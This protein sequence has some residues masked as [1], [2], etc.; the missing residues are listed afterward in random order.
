[1]K[2]YYT[3]GA[4]SL[5]AHIILNETGLPHEVEQVDLKAKKTAS[6]GDYL[7]INPRGAVPALEI[8]PG[9]VL[10]Q[11]VAVLTYIGAQSDIPA[12]H[13][14][15]G[16]LEQYRLLEAIGFCEDV[17]SAFGPMFAPDLPD[18]VRDRQLA[19]IK[20][21]M[22]Q[23][24]AMLSASGD[25]HMLPV[26]FT[27]ADALLAVILSWAPHVNVDLSPYPEASALRDRVFARPAAQK[28]MKEEGLA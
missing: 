13:P 21:R 26:G 14:A 22:T 16:S 28:A 19:N 2:L 6:G 18:V 7:A 5:A 11:N 8:A 15:P 1:M 4:C 3:P 10:T 25:D 20:R 9:V 24:E 12:L 23:V 27:Q 17:H